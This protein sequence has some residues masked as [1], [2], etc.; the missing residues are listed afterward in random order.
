VKQR[1]QR[2]TAYWIVPQCLLSLMSDSIQ[3]C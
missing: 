3:D 1:L 2:N